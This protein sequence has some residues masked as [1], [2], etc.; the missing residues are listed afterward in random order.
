M[1]VLKKALCMI[2]SALILSLSFPA[3][4]AYAAYE[5]A[6]AEKN[7]QTANSSKFTLMVYMCG[8][9]LESEA[10]MG[11]RDINEMIDGCSGRNVNIIL[12]TG[13]AKKWQNNVIPSKKSRRYRI[14][15][16]G[17]TVADDS[18]G[19]KKMTDPATLSSFISFCKKNYPS[20]RYGLILW[21]HGG[22]SLEGFGRDENFSKGSDHMTLP[23][24]K[25]ALDKGG[26]D[27][28]FIGFDACLMNSFETA[29][30][31]K[32]NADYLIAAEESEFADGWYYTDWI[33]SLCKDP[34]IPVTKLGKQ[35][36][37]SSIERI[38]KEIPDADTN[39]SVIDLKKMSAVNTALNAFSRKLD[40]SLRA[41]NYL[42]ISQNRHYSDGNSI[43]SVDAEAI[44][45]YDFTWEF[46]D[47]PKME[48]AA[49]NLMEKLDNAIAYNR[50]SSPESNLYGISICFPYYYPKNLD[51]LEN[52]YNSAGMKNSD[53]ITFLKRFMNI[54][55]G[56]QEYASGKAEFR[57]CRWYDK[58]KFYKQ[59]YYKKYCLSDNDKSLKLKKTSDGAALNI[60]DEQS[61]ALAVIN[62]SHYVYYNDDSDEFVMYMGSDNDFESKKNTRTGTTLYLNNW[63]WFMLDDE[64]VPIQY[65][66]S[67][68]EDD[69]NYTHYYSMYCFYNDREAFLYFKWES[70]MKSPELIYWKSGSDTGSGREI[71]DGDIVEPIYEILYADT[72]DIDYLT[73]VKLTM[74]DNEISFGDCT[75]INEDA[76]PVICLH[77][78][79]LFDNCYSSE[80]YWRNSEAI[81]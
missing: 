47:D 5:K 30:T 19:Q 24:I 26:A 77:F 63:H 18:L 6:Y 36:A 28:E 12:Q 44:D 53:Y 22:G 50:T 35:I 65:K 34:G 20:E 38:N 9:D 4:P 52:V 76:Q 74:G 56:A 13:G 25:S 71:K 73:P 79:D 27:F 62:V 70:E 67:V 14:T 33:S 10:G 64:Y 58:S 51:E 16:N 46:S 21:D 15:G 1:G 23:E 17:L 78:E 57:K 7:V 81:F 45:L 43:G 48:R 29:M 39:I 80:F 59:S 54:L 2:S 61:D 37:D 49:D 75:Y 66:Y 60:T 72:D 31:L 8:S 42:D 40:E 68:R 41:G 55:A 3:A 32:D 11:T 69:G